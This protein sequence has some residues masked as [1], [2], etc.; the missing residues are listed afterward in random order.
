MLPVYVALGGALGALARYGVYVWVH[1]WAGS[2]FPWGTFVVNAVGCLLIGF[3]VRVLDGVVWGA[4]GRAF[5]TVGL[6]GG[7][8][9]FS[10]FGYET[11]AM[12]ES[13]DGVRAALY[14]LGSVG[15]GVTAV[16]AGIA[17]AGVTIQAGG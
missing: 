2:R 11:L 15:V 13:G 5:L 7:F 3:T 17:L 6:L 4:E 10:T 16:L 14:V 12:I 9:T 8:T 1:G